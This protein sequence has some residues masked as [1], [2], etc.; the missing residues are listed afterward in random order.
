M[1]SL[2][3]IHDEFVNTWTPSKYGVFN[4]Y[5]VVN[6]RSFDLQDV[7]QERFPGIKWDLLVHGLC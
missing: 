1:V 6:L 5:F 7:F 2:Y 4:G 3:T